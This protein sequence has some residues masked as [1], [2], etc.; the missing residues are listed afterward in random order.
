MAI[1]AETRTEIIQ[2][3]VAMFDAAPGAT[4]LSDFV[5]QIEAGASVA[6]LAEALAA[7]DAFK[8]I[9][10]DLLTSN[11]FATKFI[12][13]L[14]GSEASDANKA[15]A[16]AQI[17]S[18]LNAG[19]SKA[20]VISWA[21]NALKAVPT[22]DPNWGNA[23]AAFNNQV[24]VAEWYSVDQLGS[25]TSLA[26][27]QNAIASVTSDAATVTA[28]TSG[29]ALSGQTFDLTTGVDTIVGTSSNDTINASD[30][31]ITGLDS[32]DGGDGVDTLNVADVAG[33]AADLTL[34]SV[35]NV[36]TLNFAST[37]GLNGNSVDLSGWSGLTSATLDLRNAAAPQTVT[38][39][40]TTD[41]TVTNTAAQNL[42]V[43]GGKDVTIANGNAAVTV[44]GAAGVASV[45]VTGG[46]T[47][48]I[49]DNG[50]EDDTLTSVSVSGNAGA[51]TVNSDALTTLK[52]ANTNQN[53]TVNAAA[54][55]RELAVTVDKVSGGTITDAEAT[56]VTVAATGNASSGTTLTFAKATTLAFSGDQTVSTALGA[57]AAGL[58]ISSTNSAGVTITT[59]LNTAVG[60]TGGDGDD[61]ITLSNGATASTNMGAGDD[62]VTVAAALGSGGAVEGG[63][64]NDTL[65]VNAA[66][67]SLTGIT[68]FEVLGLGG[69]ATGAYSADGF[70]GLT[71]GA[72]TGAVTY[73]NVAAGTGLT[74]TATTSQ[75]ATY[76]LADATGASDALDL[77]ITGAGAINANTLT[78]AGV[79]SIAI[80]TDDT[81]ATATGINHTLTIAGNDV[82]TITVSGDAGLSLTANSTAL[83]SFDA[84]GTTTAG[85]AVSLTTGALANAATLSGGAGGD[86]LV[87]TAAT[88]AVTLNGNGGNDTLTANN[89]QDN[90][91]NGGDGN[92]TI[93]TGAG[94]DTIDAGAGDDTIDSGTGLDTLTG[95]DGDDTFVMSVSTA[96]NIYTSITD[97]AAG[98]SL[99]LT[100]LDAQANAAIANAT[101]IGAGI[102]LASTAVFQ[103][104]LDAAAADTTDAG[105]DGNLDVALVNWFQFGGDTFVVVDQSVQATF[106]T[107]QDSV[108]KLAGL[109]DLSTADIAAAVLTL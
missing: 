58:A 48:T 88:K 17:E 87:A 84:S 71:H 9:Y 24:S 108:V 40:D 69:S 103:D 33:A 26:D 2:L 39:A 49:N 32:I 59:A 70:T 45:T 36:E 55:T 19:D 7:T 38:V 3:V 4:Y 23:A 76:T 34:L 18:K 77:T 30:T 63:D 52:V 86:T 67:F 46:S 5:N 96:G 27:L 64:G 90:T 79:E 35:S 99:D 65:V 8:S 28:A 109:I 94:S 73:N 89:A 75:A 106:Q 6:G 105:G 95:G 91:V 83:T 78:A 44:N 85:S 62:K 57:Q 50:T 42:T 37:S 74:I 80:T 25:A 100:G 13:N 72:L 10:P 98:D 82:E 21:Y 66:S 14:V 1:T 41:V 101:D 53:A 97:F 61:V 12:D 60:F 104:Y 102:T 20:S 15:W 81:A 92:D 11:E 93:T 16:V 54:G 51:A 31:T 68:G 43:S 29:S 56:S 47:V 107:G 22:D